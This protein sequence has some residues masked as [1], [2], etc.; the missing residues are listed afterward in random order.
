[1]YFHK[2][3]YFNAAELPLSQWPLGWA[4]EARVQLQPSPKSELDG[5]YPTG[6]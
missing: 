4:M 3:A 6:Q 2:N 1:M 5:F